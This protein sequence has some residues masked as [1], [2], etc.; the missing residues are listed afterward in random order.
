MPNGVCLENLAADEVSKTIEMAFPSNTLSPSS[1]YDRYSRLYSPSSSLFQAHPNRYFAKMK[2][3]NFCK[4]IEEKADSEASSTTKPV[5]V[6]GGTRCGH[7][8]TSG[9]HYL[10]MFGGHG[11]GG[12][13]SRY[14][15][16]YN[17][18]VVL[19]RVSIQWKR[20]ATNTEVPEGI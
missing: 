14:D 10:F 17:D 1:R 7:T 19:D 5:N 8:V 3:Q 13:L 15:V 4:H 18:C 16:Y 20:L 12:W 6:G 9:G 2:M 11:T